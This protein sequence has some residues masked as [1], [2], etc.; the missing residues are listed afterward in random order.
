ME[1]YN[2]N[3]SK[4]MYKKEF[5]IL[6]VAVGAWIYALE[7]LEEK[8]DFFTVPF[9]FVSCMLFAAWFIRGLEKEDSNDK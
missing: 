6:C 8:C 7:W 5:F 9:L 4:Y 1:K 2:N 3:K